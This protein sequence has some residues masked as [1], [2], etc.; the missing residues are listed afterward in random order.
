MEDQV[1]RIIAT[2]GPILPIQ[3]AKETGSNTMIAGA[4][5]SKLASDRKIFISNTKIGG[6]PVYYLKEQLHKLQDLYKYLNEKDKRT[7][8]LLRKNRIIRDTEQD[9][10]TRVS[11]RNIKDFAVPLEVTLGDKKET[12][13]KWYLTN[14]DE[15]TGL[16]RS[17]LNIEKESVSKPEEKIQKETQRELEK[18][19]STFVKYEKQE[20]DKKE[21][22]TEEKKTEKQAETPKHE[23]E[24]DRSDQFVSKIIKFLKEKGI[25]V[26]NIEVRKKNSEI[27]FILSVPTIVGSLEYYC[28]AKNKSKISD[29]DISSAYVQGQLRKLPA[30][31]ITPGVLTK[32][33]SQLLEKDVKINIVKI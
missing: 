1:M 33:A 10:L 3:I 14:D 15:A 20:Q 23:A 21:E 30:M 25:S 24:I 7:F 8:E 16:I 26:K 4:V 12:F 27:D 32:K 5:L 29:A 19:I 31:L 11:L 28:K 22:K 17:Y 2:K 6:S 18:P 13:W 9:A